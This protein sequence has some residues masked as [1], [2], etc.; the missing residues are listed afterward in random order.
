[1]LEVFAWEGNFEVVK[2]AL[3]V[4]LDMARKVGRQGQKRN[5]ALVTSA[6]P[7]VLRLSAATLPLNTCSMRSAFEWQDGHIGE[8]LVGWPLLYCDC[9]ADVNSTEGTLVRA[10]SGPAQL[11]RTA[12][13]RRI[14]PEAWPS[15]ASRVQAQPSKQL[16][17]TDGSMQASQGRRQ[18]GGRNV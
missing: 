13:Q 7:A 10:Q 1:M 5:E 15:V 9:V 18:S 3:S 17:L 8:L 11:I 6:C 12:R 2:P 4:T 16:L 14:L